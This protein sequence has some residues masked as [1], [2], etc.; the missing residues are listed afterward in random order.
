LQQSLDTFAVPPAE[1]ADVR[2]PAAFP[3]GIKDALTRF[4]LGA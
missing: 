3:T 1:Q 4:A 2:E